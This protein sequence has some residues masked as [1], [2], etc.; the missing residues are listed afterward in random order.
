M[1]ELVLLVGLST[2]ALVRRDRCSIPAAGIPLS[3]LSAR[4]F[5]VPLCT[6]LLLYPSVRTQCTCNGCSRA[7]SAEV[8]GG[9][10]WLSVECPLFRCIP[11]CARVCGDATHVGL[12]A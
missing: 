9:E 11:I 5:P 12:Q 1:Y 8:R 6:C 4:R 7:K 2:N 10:C 3:L